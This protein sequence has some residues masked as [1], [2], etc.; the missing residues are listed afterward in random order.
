MKA[1]VKAATTTSNDQ[2]INDAMDRYASGDASAFEDLY[3]ALAP[4]LL[5]FL[6]RGT[7][8]DALAEELL[9]Q[10]FLQIHTARERYVTG[11]DA[12]PWAFAIARRLRIDAFRRTRREVAGVVEDTRDAPPD[13]CPHETLA[14]RETAKRLQQS[15]AELPENQREAFELVKSQGLSHAQAA[16]VL[17]TTVTATKLRVHRACETLRLVARDLDVD[18]EV[19]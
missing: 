14:A 1:E 17:G 2:R 11:F 7:S 16:A 10:T 15:L 18:A 9:Q 12:V 8:D 13:S 19:T 4:R 5:A 6:R 3:D